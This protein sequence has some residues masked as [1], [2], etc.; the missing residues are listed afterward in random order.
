M[1]TEIDQI[2]ESV[3]S[4]VRLV[5]TLA[6]LSRYSIPVES[7]AARHAAQIEA[8]GGL[9]SAKAVLAGFLA[10]P[11]LITQTA[12]SMSWDELLPYATRLP[13]AKLGALLPERLW[14]AVDAE[15]VVSDGE[16]AKTDELE[17]RTLAH[18][19]ARACEI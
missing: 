4:G 15:I 17:P 14:L 1:S 5:V 19:L 6:D 9:S 12:L 16:I 2:D 3:L 18:M 8:S 10:D 13:D 7:I 11:E